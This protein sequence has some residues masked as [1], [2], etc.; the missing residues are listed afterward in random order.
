M[1]LPPENMHGIC[2]GYMA[3]IVQAFSW[4]QNLRAWEATEDNADRGMHYVFLFSL[5]KS[6]T[7]QK[8]V[9]LGGL[10]QQQPDP[11]EPARATFFLINPDPQKSK[12]KKAQMWGVLF[13]LLYFMV[14]SDNCKKLARMIGENTFGVHK[15]VWPNIATGSFFDQGRFTKDEDDAT[16]KFIPKYVKDFVD[17]VDWWEVENELVEIHLL[18]H[19]WLY[20]LICGELHLKNRTNNL[21]GGQKCA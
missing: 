18:K 20:V 2:F 3:H 11:E 6:W 15:I 14:L 7:S 9:Q 12:K 5:Q 21:P 17:C 16:E 13:T 8:L 19:L 4:V 10:L 1:T